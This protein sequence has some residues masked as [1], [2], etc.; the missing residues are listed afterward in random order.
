ML[1]L[2]MRLESSIYEGQNFVFA[3]LFILVAIATVAIIISV[4]H[5]QTVSIGIDKKWYEKILF[6]SRVNMTHHL[7]VFKNV[8][9][10]KLL[11]VSYDACFGWSG[12]ESS[13]VY[14]V[15]EILLP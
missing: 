10:F 14:N 4:K 13:C 8:F 9:D 11:I 3:I 15:Y 5:I 12:W 2:R 1:R 6:V 7:Y